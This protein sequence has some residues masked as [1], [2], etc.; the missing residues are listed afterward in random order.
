VV[1]ADVPDHSESGRRGIQVEVLRE[2]G[3][4][5][6][7][8]ALVESEVTQARMILG[9]Y[10]RPFLI[11]DGRLGLWFERDGAI[12]LLCFDPETL[13]PMLIAK[14]NDAKARFVCAGDPVAT[15]TIPCGLPEGEH[16]HA[17]PKEM[18]TVE[19]LFLIALNPHAGPRDPFCSIL[20]LLPPQDR[21]RVFPQKWFTSESVD[22]G[23]QW[24]TRAARD[25]SSGH[26]V[27]DGIRIDGF[28]LD[29]DGCHRVGKYIRPPDESR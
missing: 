9:T 10:T 21:V 23:Y 12:V 24:I 27:G 6:L 3:A 17:F 2:R 16:R 18:Q 28:E 15:T 5:R 7:R 29:D 19:E 14:P 20:E 25:A 26:I 8:V 11:P 4:T 1:L 22:V 13:T